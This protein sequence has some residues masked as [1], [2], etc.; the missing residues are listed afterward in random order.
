MPQ[1]PGLVPEV[2][3]SVGATPEVNVAAPVEA[4]G[5][6]VGHAISGLGKAVD[7]AGDEIWKQAVKIQEMQNKTEADRAETEYMEKTGLMHAEFNAL[8]GGNATKAY[9]KYIGDLKTSR[10]EIRGRL[11]NDAVRRAYD[12]GTQSTMG[13][14]IFSG[15]AHAAMQARAAQID[16][17]GKKL[18]VTMSRAATA[19][20]EDEFR[21]E[22]QKALDLAG[23]DNSL[24][25]RN[26]TKEDEFN[27]NSSLN[28][29]RIQHV[30]KTDP[31][32]AEQMLNEQRK[33]LSAQEFKTTS[34]IVISSKRSTG[35]ANI[36]QDVWSRSVKDGT[37]GNLGEMQAQAR[38]QAEVQFPN[39]EI[40]A[41]HAEIAVS[42]L[43]NRKRQAETADQ[44]DATNTISGLIMGGVKTEQELLA[45]P[46]G[47][48]AYFKLPET[49][50]KGIP[51][52]INN[53]VRA[54][55]QPT[56]Q[57]NYRR[58]KGLA[59]SD[60][61]EA[62]AKFLEADLTKEPLNQGDMNSL[63]SKRASMLK[64][65]SKDAKSDPRAVKA[66]GFIR[67]A[68]GE[69]LQALR[70]YRRPDSPD[71]YDKFMGAL[72]DSIENFQ[73]INKKPPTEKQII[74]EIAPTLLQSHSVPKLW[75][76][77][78][79]TEQNYVVPSEFADGIKAKATESGITLDDR[80]IRRAYIQTLMKRYSK[81]TGKP[82]GGK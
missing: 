73:E 56:N 19:D 6:A 52:Q 69:Q 40:A 25:G 18:S 24:R 66:M 32:R 8:Q 4:F 67:A 1:V 82:D 42:T 2:K 3:A 7:H 10:E 74:D 75:G 35:A 14:T 53:Y 28:S 81:P 49:V 20:N 39:D 47:R 44:R 65:M 79:G 37:P 9:P 70:I 38:K 63:M 13:R 5:G 45:T 22:R 11:S 41:N 76:L 59:F 36:A 62:V 21:I 15:G 71:E 31:Y 17:V 26:S 60:N 58:L 29:A 48:D 43:Y 12:S 54:A 27:I 61:E 57:E 16:A 50:R 51:A 30:A 78:T 64:Q 34:D 46:E 55:N 80:Q 72:H 68:R 33:S 23:E 77:Y